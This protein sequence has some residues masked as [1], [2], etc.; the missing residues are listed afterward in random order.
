MRTFLGKL[1]VS[2]AL[3]LAVALA[4]AQGQ[5]GAR[6]SMCGGM[7]A[8]AFQPPT[9]CGAN[10][11]LETGGY[12]VFVQTLPRF[13]PFYENWEVYAYRPTRKLQVLALNVTS[14][15]GIATGFEQG[16]WFIRVQADVLFHLSW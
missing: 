10:A 14:W 15:P 11:F 12:G 7:E 5:A 9:L 6:L 16:H 1:L 2:L 4:G 3:L 13:G 8:G